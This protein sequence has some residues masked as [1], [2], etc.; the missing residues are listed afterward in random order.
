MESCRSWK[1]RTTSMTPQKLAASI[2]AG[3]VLML[4]LIFAYKFLGDLQ[5]TNIAQTPQANETIRQA[6]ES[7]SILEFG[8]ALADEIEFW[9][10]SLLVIGGAFWFFKDHLPI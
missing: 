7:I 9:A 8:A 1:I 5:Q 2:A 3:L 10:I 6:T 4:V